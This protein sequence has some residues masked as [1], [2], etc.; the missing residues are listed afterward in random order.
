MNNKKTQ[1]LFYQ[2]IPNSQSYKK[3]EN[4]ITS[5]EHQID[6]DSVNDFNS[7]YMLRGLKNTKEFG[8]D[9]IN[10]NEL[11]LLKNKYEKELT[12]VIKTRKICFEND[13]M[14]VYNIS[15]AEESILQKIIKDLKILIDK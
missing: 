11:E 13:N 6:Y 2:V 8:Y 3:L 10:Y 12:R 7:E 4:I 9:L 14:E 1:E 15:C 5:I